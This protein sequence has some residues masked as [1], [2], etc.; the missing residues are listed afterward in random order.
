MATRLNFPVN[1]RSFGFW[2]EQIFALANDYRASFPDLIPPDARTIE[3]LEDIFYPCLAFGLLEE[4]QQTQQLEFQYYDSL[5]DS[6]YTASLSPEW[7]Q[8]LEELANRKD[9]ATALKTL[10]DEE[11]AQIERQPELWE[12]ENLPKLR[13]FVKEVDQLPEDN[14]NYPYKATVVGTPVS[15][16]LTAKEGIIIRFRKKMDERFRNI[17]QKG[18]APLTNTGK[19]KAITGEIVVASPV[20]S[21]NNREKRRLEFELLQQDLA[22]GVITKDEYEYLRC[23]ILNKY[24]L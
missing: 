3:N 22:N 8:A 21:N 4:N 18:L 7:S 9:M 14:S 15:A 6:Y 19:Q 1:L 2:R 13:Q 24:P 11:I 16:D 12:N 5:R 20:C 17:S 10:L 23:E